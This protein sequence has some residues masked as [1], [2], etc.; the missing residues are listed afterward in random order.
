[1]TLCCTNPTSPPPP[2]P[3]RAVGLSFMFACMPTV[4]YKISLC[5]LLFFQN[6]ASFA[7]AIR[8]YIFTS[9]R[10]VLTSSSCL[11]RKQAAKPY[12][13]V[14]IPK[15]S[16]FSIVNIVFSSFRSCHG[17]LEQWYLI[18]GKHPVLKMW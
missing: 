16:T 7:S 12:A 5:F 8:K 3:P 10:L 11:I 9:P 1:M 13:K 18:K 14:G 17:L 4:K 15:F 6:I 2:P